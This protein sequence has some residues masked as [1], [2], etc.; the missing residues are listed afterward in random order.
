MTSRSARWLLV[1][2][3]AVVIAAGSGEPLPAAP[4]TGSR[5]ADPFADYPP[6][7][8]WAWNYVHKPALRTARVVIGYGGCS[9][10]LEKVKGSWRAMTLT[11]RWVT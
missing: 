2:T 9:V 8:A 6:F 5:P 10:V 1:G 4:G 11:N 7:E 3:V